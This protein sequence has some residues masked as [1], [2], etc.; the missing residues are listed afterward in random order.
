MS[1]PINTAGRFVI[2]TITAGWGVRPE[3]FRWESSATTPPATRQLERSPV[4]E[5]RDLAIERDQAPP[6]E[7]RAGPSPPLMPQY[8]PTRRPD[9]GPAA[10][11]QP[12]T[13][14]RDAAR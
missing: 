9:A 4:L 5:A 10:T 13:S 12:A 8:P 14:R 2:E 3:S 7:C 6:V 1:V 11:P